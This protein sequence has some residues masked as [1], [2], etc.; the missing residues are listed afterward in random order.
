[1]K[2]LKQ[3][4]K[5]ATLC[6]SLVG[7]ND[8]IYPLAEYEEN[9]TSNKI[10][11]NASCNTNNINKIQRYLNELIHNVKQSDQWIE[12]PNKYDY[13]GSEASG[14][15]YFQNTENHNDW[16]KLNIINHESNKEYLVHLITNGEF[17]TRTLASYIDKNGDYIHYDG[18][19]FNSILIENDQEQIIC[20]LNNVIQ[21][22]NLESYYTLNSR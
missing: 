13:S 5:Y 7:C 3:L 9:F 2:S 1:M 11:Y 16:I 4:A 20:K 10:E 14:T 15:I 6:L 8:H 12:M 22:T 18:V 19:H 21:I 17:I